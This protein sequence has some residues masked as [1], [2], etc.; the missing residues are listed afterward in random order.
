MSPKSSKSFER[1]KRL[2]LLSF[3]FYVPAFI[4]FQFESLSSRKNPGLIPK[5][6]VPAAPIK[7]LEGRS[8][9]IRD[10]RAVEGVVFSQDF[11]HETAGLTER[12]KVFAP[13]L[14]VG[15]VRIETDLPALSPGHHHPPLPRG[16]RLFHT[17]HPP[18]K[19][20][21]PEQ[22]KNYKSKAPSNSILHALPF[23]L[24]FLA[25]KWVWAD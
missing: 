20:S 7:S 25:K 23:Q 8:L 3:R 2:P 14:I 10:C 6:N 9:L 22:S 18:I 15:E 11:P 5:E 4:D 17:P 21:P 19:S 13:D 24:K 12:A 1:P 16:R